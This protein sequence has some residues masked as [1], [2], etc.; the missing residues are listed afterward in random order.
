MTQLST[1]PV[2]AL[3][4]ADF[5][6]L[7]DRGNGFAIDLYKRLAGASGNVA[8]CPHSVWAAL[9]M[10]YAGARGDTAVEM[11]A[12]LGVTGFGQRAHAGLA[13]LAR[14]LQGDGTEGQPDFRAANA[15]W[16]QLGVTL[17]PEFVALSRTHSGAEP[18]TADFAG[19]P[20][21][22]RRAINGW[23]SERTGGGIPEL[24]PPT[25]SPRRRGW[26]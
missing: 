1:Q 16:C 13:D 4:E 19:D 24:L 21:G 14:R 7:V 11:A 10:A 20:E 2:S 5:E 6:A 17:K 3:T 25:P 12:V 18:G 23:V 8:C 26:C 9:T 15:L 22:A